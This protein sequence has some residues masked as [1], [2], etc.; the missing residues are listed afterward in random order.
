MA[1][2]PPAPATAL[3]GSGR[4]AATPA[5][6]FIDRVPGMVSFGAAL[7]CRHVAG[8][9]RDGQS[10]CFRD[11]GPRDGGTRCGGL[12]TT[13]SD[14]AG[15]AP[16][17]PPDGEAVAGPAAGGSPA[18]YAM[19]RGRPAAE[20]RGGRSGPAHR[21][22]GVVLGDDLE[23]PGRK[24]EERR[25]GVGVRPAV[26]GAVFLHRH[27]VDHDELGVPPGDAAEVAG[28]LV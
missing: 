4:P 22:E 15:P 23:S 21:G 12:F 16:A 26:E 8:G 10:P 28:P 2:P 9:S 18:G 3:P 20:P 11:D 14:I 25:A 1:M 13:G 7:P 6:T 24:P 5:P 17:V 19:T 27:Q